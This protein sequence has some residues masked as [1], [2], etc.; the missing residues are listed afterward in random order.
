MKEFTEA[1]LHLAELT[2]QG[3]IE[4]RKVSDRWLYFDKDFTITIDLSSKS[5]TIQDGDHQP[6]FE[7]EILGQLVELQVAV[8][9]SP[10]MKLK[11]AL[12]AI[13]DKK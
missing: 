11:K 13:M 12:T 6:L 2:N 5:I 3:K 8:Q 9:K 10:S 7:E 4:W 1:M